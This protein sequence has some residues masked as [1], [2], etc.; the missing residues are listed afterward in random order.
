MDI[1]GG[2][3]IKSDVKLLLLYSQFNPQLFIFFRHAGGVTWLV[4]NS[5]NRLWPP[6]GSSPCGEC[7]W[8]AVIITACVTGS[9]WFRVTQGVTWREKGLLRSFIDNWNRY[10][11][12][13][14]LIDKYSFKSYFILWGW[15][16]WNVC[17]QLTYRKIP[18]VGNHEKRKK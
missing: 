9:F 4:L 3:K 11:D 7:T 13:N 1:R 2:A 15:L 17:S 16:S 6:F 8:R 5:R 18:T 12:L 10:R 14:I